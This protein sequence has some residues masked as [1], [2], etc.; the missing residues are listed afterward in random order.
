MF[1]I[2]ELIIGNSVYNYIQLIGEYEYNKNK[3]KM[4][5]VLIFYE[6]FWVQLYT[7]YWGIWIQYEWH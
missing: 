4:C 2:L 3:I 6:L 5:Y 1:Y 7:I